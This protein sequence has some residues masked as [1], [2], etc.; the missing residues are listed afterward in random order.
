M[1]RVDLPEKERRGQFV[2]VPERS[3]DPRD[4]EVELQTKVVFGSGEWSQAAEFF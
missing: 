3:W 2:A 4:I 1:P